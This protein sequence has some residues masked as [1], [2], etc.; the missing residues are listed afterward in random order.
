MKPRLY[1]FSAAR[2]QTRWLG[3]TFPREAHVRIYEPHHR[4][5]LQRHDPIHQEYV[6]VEIPHCVLITEGAAKF[7]K[8][9]YFFAAS[10]AIEFETELSVVGGLA[11]YG[12]TSLGIICMNDFKSRSLDETADY[13]WNST[14]T[15]AHRTY[16]APRLYSTVNGA[17][18]RTSLRL[19]LA[20]LGYSTLD[21]KID[22]PPIEEHDHVRG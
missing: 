20:C 17:N 1:H 5:I 2:T 15:L 8:N 7:S 14:F 6:K 9:N 21:A 22:F 4:M 19:F 16:E 13:F 11:N 3:L 18:H 10:E 12:Y